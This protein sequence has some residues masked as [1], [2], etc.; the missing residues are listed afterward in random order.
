M[1]ILEIL[2]YAA[3]LVF[4]VAFAAK[5]IKYF[6]MPMHVRWELYPIPHE[7]KPYGGSHFE[8]VDHWTKE[9]HKD[10]LAVY[11]FMIPEILLIR[12]LYE[13]NKPL[14]YLVLPLSIS[15]FIWVLLDWHSWSLAHFC[16]YLGSDLKQAH[17]QL[18]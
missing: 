5:I 7:G 13:H 2:T 1:G 17:C 10:H 11:K 9:R 18:C 3:G 12:A 4:I 16:K 15:G 14:W 8:E 6:T